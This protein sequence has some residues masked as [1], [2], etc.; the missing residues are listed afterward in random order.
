MGYHNIELCGSKT[1]S[2]QIIK[3][4]TVYHIKQNF[5]LHGETVIMPLDCI[6]KFEGGTLSNGNI[7]FDSTIIESTYKNI[8][9]HISVSG[10]LANLEVRM[11]WWELAY[12]KKSNDAVLINQVIRAIDNCIFLLCY[13]RRCLCRY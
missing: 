5:D 12:N 3:E 13:T 8:F 7:V 9:D 10:T 6:L 11:S 2:S 1:F 4:H